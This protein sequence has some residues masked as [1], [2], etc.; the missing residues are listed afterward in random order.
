MAQYDHHCTW[1]NNCI[2]KHN[3]GRFV[4]F[5]GMVECGIGWIGWV[6]AEVVARISKGENGD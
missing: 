2:G 4:G 3:L 6:S 1:V 5:I